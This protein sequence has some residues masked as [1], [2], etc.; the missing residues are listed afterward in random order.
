MDFSAFK[1]INSNQIFNII[2]TLH[3][4]NGLQASAQS[5]VL[6][7]NIPDAIVCCETHKRTHRTTDDTPH[8]PAKHIVD[9][10]T[11]ARF[12]LKSR[13]ERLVRLRL[14]GVFNIAVEVGR[15][16]QAVGV[17]VLWNRDTRTSSSRRSGTVIGS[18]WQCKW[19]D[20]SASKNNV[21]Y[22]CMSGL[23]NADDSL[24]CVYANCLGNLISQFLVVFCAVTFC[25][26]VICFSSPYMG[27]VRS[28]LLPESLSWDCC[29]HNFVR[30]FCCFT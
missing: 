8:K 13:R 17:V 23:I 26:F 18:G 20:V 28:C 10:I 7:L 6:R 16:M 14:E 30:L 21:C 5:I 11:D 2:I 29:S 9:I 1:L 24:L 15:R 4:G 22:I 12:G 3:I 25:S 27:R 19:L